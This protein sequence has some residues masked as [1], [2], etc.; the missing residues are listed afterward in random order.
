M[1]NAIVERSEMFSATRFTKTVTASTYKRLL[2]AK[3]NIQPIA[4]GEKDRGAVVAI[5]SALA[6]LNTNYLSSSDVDGYFGP[7]TAAAVEAFQRDYGLACDRIVGRQV[8]TQLDA[9]FSPDVVRAPHAVSIHLG[10][11]RVD[12]GHYGS[13]LKL[14]SCANDARA[15]A[16]IAT[17]VGYDPVV[18]VDEEATTANFAAFIR[19]CGS[20][21]FADDCLMISFSG[22]GSQV[23]NVSDDAESDLMDETMCFHDRMLI[24]DEFYGLL[25]ELKAG[26]RVHIFLDSC[27]SGTAVKNV[28]LSEAQIKNEHIQGTMKSLKETPRTSAGRD[29]GLTESDL[30]PITVASLDKALEGEQP[31]LIEVPPIPADQSK[32]IATLFGE[33]YSAETTGT[34]KFTDGQQVYEKNQFLYDTVKSV[35]GYKEANRLDCSAVSVSAA[36]DPQTTPAGNPLSLFTYN[37]TQVWASGAFDGSYDQFHRSLLARSPQDSTPQLNTYGSGGSRAR[38]YE[39]PFM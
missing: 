36:A 2:L 14:P 18:L 16:E 1:A 29:S 19:T 27:H 30:I 38:T 35:I 8:L 10:V 13:D 22:H 6:A 20:N 28:K 3:D 5:Q 12:P 25:T 26:V 37:L 15:M 39:R 11:D 34:V 17:S 31:Q 32:D 23:P 9:L 24:D 4:A 21:L 7:R 33:L